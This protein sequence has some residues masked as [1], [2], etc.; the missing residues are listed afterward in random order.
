[1]KQLLVSA[2][3]FL[4]C[5]AAYSQVDT[6]KVRAIAGYVHQYRID[7]LTELSNDSAQERYFSKGAYDRFFD[8]YFTQIKYERES[9]TEGNS[10]ALNITDNKTRLNLTLSQKT[11]N[12]I[13]SLGTALNISDNTGMLFSKDKPTSGTEFSGSFSYLPQHLRFLKYQGPDQ[14][15]NYRKRHDLLDSLYDIYYLKNPNYADLLLE[16]IKNLDRLY[17]RYDSIVANERNPVIKAAFKD[18]LVAT[19]DKRIKANQEAQSLDDGITTAED[20]KSVLIKKAEEL[21]INKQLETDGVTMFRFQWFTGGVSYRRDAYS[22]YDSLLSFSKR[23]NSKDFDKWTLNATYNF[24]WQRTDSWI[25]FRDSKFIN[26]FYANINYALVRSNSFED[27]K[28]QTLSITRARVQNDTTYEFA[29]QKKVR[30]I[31]KKEYTTNWTHR[32][33]VVGTAMMGKKQF[34]GLN[35]SGQTE[36]KP[37][38]T[39]LN[40][41]LGLLFRFKDSETEKSKVNFELFL[42]LADLS[43]EGKTNKSAWERKEIGISANVPFQKVFFR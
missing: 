16:K 33:G 41:R 13:F 25:A 18:S 23:I 35:V 8:K 43:D 1:M 22:T 15:N 2:F 4:F 3:L 17:Y 27:L 26:S 38:S 24:F 5:F 37:E 9:F 42:S 31:S 6:A 21:K 28:D 36:I 10:A 40:T 20:F 11:N 30:D 34:F 19:I 32:I 39:V 12:W 7:Q 14:D 29:T